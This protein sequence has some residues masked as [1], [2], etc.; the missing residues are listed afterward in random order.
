MTCHRLTIART[1]DWPRGG[2]G[3]EEEEEENDGGDEFSQQQQ[4]MIRRHLITDVCM[5]FLEMS[6]G[7]WL[8]LALRLATWIGSTGGSTCT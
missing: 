5:S 2:G 7:P 6:G 1:S 8:A 3:G 4:K